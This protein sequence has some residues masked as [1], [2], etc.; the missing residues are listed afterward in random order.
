MMFEAL[1]ADHCFDKHG[2]SERIISE[3]IKFME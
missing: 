2:G 1:H 3:I